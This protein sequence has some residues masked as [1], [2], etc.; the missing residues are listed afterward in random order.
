MDW[1]A[2]TDAEFRA[3]V[4]AFLAE[5]YPE[6]L[7]HPPH[8][9]RLV[10]VREW[11]QTLSR[12]GWLAPAW[13]QEH[14]GMGLGPGKLVILIEE[15]ENWGVARLPDHGI[16][17]VGP[18]L[19]QQGSAQQK[20]YYLPRILSGEHI[21]CQG[22]SEPN[23]GSDLAS[24]RT[25]AELDGDHFVVNGQ[26]T[27]STLAQD[28]THMFMLV[29]TSAMARKQDGISFLLVDMK[30]PGIDVR[31]IRTLT[32]QD[33]FCDVFFDDVR[34][35]RG[36]LVGQINRGWSV[37]K[38]LLGFERLFLGSPKLVQSALGRL[39]SIA[40][41]TNAAAEPAVSDR[42]CQLRLDA[43]DLATLYRRFVARARTGEDLGPEISVL[44]V[45][46]TET[47]ARISEYAVELAGSAGAMNGNVPLGN[48]E[49]DVLSTFYAAR[50]AT[51]Y[52]GTNEIQRN[53]LATSVL[54][55]PT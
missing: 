19:M 36:N 30:T 17:M 20:E 27:W 33:E 54:K 11:Y 2:L 50:P 16:V 34:V 28:A 15:Q 7:R 25:R 18:L 49:V 10:A 26:K 37:A 12:T 3:R 53:I 6:H 21:W 55:L 46:A 23:A 47:F 35:P 38:S 41:A 43:A 39:E 8:R 14:G 1:N 51:I 4:R 52:G 9:L 45:W 40:L 31:P 44:K 48:Q 29:R 42:I 5:N 13:P 24:L 32:G 22:Y